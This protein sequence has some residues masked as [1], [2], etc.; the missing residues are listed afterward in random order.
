ML[1]AAVPGN[2]L[3]TA[4]DPDLARRQWTISEQL[5]GSAP[6]SSRPGRWV[7]QERSKVPG[8]SRD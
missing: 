6:R 1:Y 2:S 8:P 3:A 7:T 4:Q 5:T